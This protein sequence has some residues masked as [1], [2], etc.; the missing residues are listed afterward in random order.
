[1][2][3]NPKQYEVKRLSINQTIR[4]LSI[5]ILVLLSFQLAAGERDL[6]SFSF[7]QMSDPQLGFAGYEHDVR[8]FEQAVK[9]VNELNPDF[10]VICGDLVNIPSDSAYADFKRIEEK[11][12]I[13]C[14]CVSGNHDMEKLPDDASLL[15]LYRKVMGKDYYSFGHKGCS[16]VVANTQLWKTDVKN[17]SEKFDRW[18][19]KKIRALGK[20]RGPLFVVGHI[21]LF[22][23]EPEEA[24]DYYNI[25]SVKRKR[26]LDLF[27]D[28][29]VAAYLTGHTH[30]LVCNEY[31]GIQFVSCETTSVN[32]DKRPLGFRLWTVSSGLITHQFIPLEQ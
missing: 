27:T 10:V 21:P 20:R 13:P 25:D 26:I 11:F 7:V 30:K 16:F 31:K 12:N 28:N 6:K 5:K 8:S 24:D 14:Y 1:M 22:I 23:S 2:G 4:L 29:K 19:T 17:E 3:G 18:F 9:Q 15:V 32:F